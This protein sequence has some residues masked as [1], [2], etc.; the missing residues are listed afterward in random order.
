MTK[1]GKAV[2]LLVV[3]AFA[4]FLLWSTLASQRVEC[5][6]TVAYGGVEGA[7]TASAA[8]EQDA[9]REAQTAACGPLAQS[10]NDRIA[11]GRVRP[12]TKQ[13]RQL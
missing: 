8:L 5:S 6:V 12:V 10:M 3:L 9:L 11:C 4:A 2:T 1:R 7:A 13:C